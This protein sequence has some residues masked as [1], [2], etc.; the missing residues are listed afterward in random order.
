MQGVL[1]FELHRAYCLCTRVW[2]VGRNK[3]LAI[4]Y[5]RTHHAFLHAPHHTTVCG[6]W[7]KRV[8]GKVNPRENVF[9]FWYAKLI[10]CDVQLQPA[11]LGAQ[12]AIYGHIATHLHVRLLYCSFVVLIVS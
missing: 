5:V 6:A 2:P 9:N 4:L 12:C 11:V 10:V 7:L 1:S 8:V 3:L